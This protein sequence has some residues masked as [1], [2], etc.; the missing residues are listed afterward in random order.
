MRVVTNDKLVRS[1]KRLAQY[2]FFFSLFLLIFGFITIN[3]P[4]LFEIEASVA[5]FLSLVLP[6]IIL[7][8]AFITSLASVRMTNWWMRVPRPEAV[9]AENLKLGKDAVLY[10]YYHLPVRHV[11]IC[12]QGVFA[13]VTRY[14]DGKHEVEGDT[15]RTPRRGLGV[16]TRLFRMDGLGD[17]FGDA[18]KAA[19]HVQSLIDPI[20][21]EVQ[22]Q[23][24]VVFTDPRAKVTITS[25]VLPVVRAQS[26]IAPSLQDY[27]KGIHKSQFQTLTPEQI[28]AFE[29]ATVA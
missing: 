4:L 17:P 18:G 22:V 15:W 28:A 14:Q 8:V 6:A 10:N 26:R 2:L 3:A 1:R 19:A 12:Q 24:V 9:L 5:N 16:L 23:G 20:A 11:L 7:P 27:I 13:L 29:A 25:P 21:P